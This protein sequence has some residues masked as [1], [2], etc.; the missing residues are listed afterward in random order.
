MN[1]FLTTVR[2]GDVREVD[3]LLR[4]DPGLLHGDDSADSTPL[5]C[6]SVRG[7]VGV[8]R[9]LLD[10][11]AAIDRQG[12]LGRHTALW[13]AC[14]S[15]HA[16]VV[17]LLMDR[18]ADPTLINFSGMT[19]LMATGVEGHVEALRVLLGYP[20]AKATTNHQE[21]NGATALYLA[22]VMGH[23]GLVRL[24]LR[25]GA[26]P[27]IASNDGSTP[28]D[29]AKMPVDDVSAVGRRICVAALEVR[30]GHP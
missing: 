11:G 16:S 14:S 2:A 8:V 22:C 27:S 15:G 25:S 6:A 17:R 12:L 29:I 26:D 21:E 9:L 3:R 19:P 24:L 23:G 10:K 1:A 7:H 13:M 4:R 30:F 20:R 28:M 18:G 5:V